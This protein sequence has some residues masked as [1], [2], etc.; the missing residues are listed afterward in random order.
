M[1]QEYWCLEVPVLS[2]LNLNVLLNLFAEIN[3]LYL[4][5]LCSYFKQYSYIYLLY[6]IHA[7]NAWRVYRI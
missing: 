7:P 6:I 4:C 5:R 1:Q 3:N 2:L